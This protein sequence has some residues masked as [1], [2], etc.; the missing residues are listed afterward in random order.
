LRGVWHSPQCA[1]ASNFEIKPSLLDLAAD[2]RLTNRLDGG[3]G[4]VA[5]RA[6]RELA[7][8]HRLSVDMNGAG[9][10]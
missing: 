10:A 7:G 1:I 4:A 6:D 2:Q 9:A 5:D 3:H 8:A